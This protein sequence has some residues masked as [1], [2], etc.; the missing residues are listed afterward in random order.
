VF[1][2]ADGQFFRMDVWLSIVSVFVLLCCNC[3]SG[4]ESNTWHLFLQLS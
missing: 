4:I 3:Q 1:K 2:F